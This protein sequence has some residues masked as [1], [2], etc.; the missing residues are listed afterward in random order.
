MLEAAPL[1]LAEPE[2]APS[3]PELRALPPPAARTPAPRLEIPRYDLAAALALERDLG[4]S[5]SLAQVLVR[6]GLSD[7]R[8]ARAFLDPREAYDPSAFDRIE[9]AIETVARHIAAGT[10]ITVHGD[11]DVDGVCATATLVRAL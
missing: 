11:Y 3:R 6:R 8:N 7:A 1:T 5:H 2:A 4:I 9:E 10:R